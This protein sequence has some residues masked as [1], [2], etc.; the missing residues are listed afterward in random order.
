MGGVSSHDVDLHFLNN[1]TFGLKER[2][3]IKTQEKEDV[4]RKCRVV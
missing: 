4:R 1:S 3:Y 2:R